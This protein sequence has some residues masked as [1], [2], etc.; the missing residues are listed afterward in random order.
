MRRICAWCKNEIEPH[1]SP[2]AENGTPVT[3]GICPACLR[4]VLQHEARSLRDFLDRFPQP[5]LVVDSDVKVITA[6]QAGLAALG[7][8]SKEIEGELGGDVF[9]CDYARL[10]QG[11][12][13][14]IHCKSCV[15][16]NTVTDTLRTGRSHIRVP[17]YPELHFL[18]G[19]KKIRFL[20]STEKVGD[21]VFL[22]IDEV[23]EY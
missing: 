12:G 22:R 18:T 13:K 9:G 8:K 15:I 10:P 4:K 14:T 21:T 20:I 5:V 1:G 17:A 6:N 7:K 3:H 16:R 11:C 19:E 23:T 2:S